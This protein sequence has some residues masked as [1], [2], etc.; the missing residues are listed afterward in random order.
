MAAKI[1]KYQYKTLIINILQ[2]FVKRICIR[3]LSS[4]LRMFHF[5]R[6][7]NGV[8]TMSVPVPA[9][10]PCSP[11]GLRSRSVC[12]PVVR[13]VRINGRISVVNHPVVHE[14]FGFSDIMR[15]ANHPVRGEGVGRMC[16]E[17][18]RQRF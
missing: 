2:L 15:F 9:T 13:I 4:V 12:V 11:N 3:L 6:T 16:G 8:R 14:S 7:P 18:C 1:Q 5:P 17:D 10:D